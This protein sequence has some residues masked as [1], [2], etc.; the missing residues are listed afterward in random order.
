MNRIYAFHLE[1]PKFNLED[2]KVALRKLFLKSQKMI[3]MSMLSLTESI[4]RS[5]S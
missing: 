3:A 2:L 4:S 5:R 1:C